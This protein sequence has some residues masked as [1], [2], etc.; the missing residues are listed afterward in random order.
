MFEFCPNLIYVDMPIADS[1]AYRSFAGCQSFK[2]IT[3]PKINWVG[4]KSF[5]GNE[6]IT[7]I[8]LPSVRYI[9]TLKLLWTVHI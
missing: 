2:K 8:N 7:E 9:F 5:N 4:Q 6:D 3:F 1:I